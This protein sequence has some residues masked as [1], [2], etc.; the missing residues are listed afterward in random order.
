MNLLLVP[1]RARTKDGYIREFIGA[2]FAV[3]DFREME[4]NEQNPYSATFWVHKR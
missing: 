4:L 1:A 3:D 2:G